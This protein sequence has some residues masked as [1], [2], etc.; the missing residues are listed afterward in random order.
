MAGPHDA[1][2]VLDKLEK[3]FDRVWVDAD[4]VIGRLDCMKGEQGDEIRGKLHTLSVIFSHLGEK[5]RSV[6]ETN[7]KQE[8]RNIYPARRRPRS[9]RSLVPVKWAWHSKV[10]IVVI[11]V[12]PVSV[13]GD[14]SGQS[15]TL[16]LISRTYMAMQDSH[17]QF[18]SR[19]AM[20]IY[21][22]R[23][24]EPCQFESPRPAIF[25]PSFQLIIR[26]HVCFI[27]PLLHHTS[28]QSNCMQII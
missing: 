10:S 21:A 11:E 18:S 9:G 26:T 24:S 25:S 22:V 4:V 12:L 14:A 13:E 7:M 8:V 17:V 15:M 1:F 3:H 27:L 5:A 19:K 6:F 16:W 2:W 20:D 28:L 23:K